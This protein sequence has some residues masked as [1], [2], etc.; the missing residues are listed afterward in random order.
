MA[1][2]G[3]GREVDTVVPATPKSTKAESTTDLYDSLP[4]WE[5]WRRTA[6]ICPKA[7]LKGQC[8]VMV[9][10]R[11]APCHTRTTGSRFYSCVIKVDC[12]DLSRVQ[13]EHHRSVSGCLGELDAVM[14]EKCSGPMNSTQTLSV[15]LTSSGLRVRASGHP[16]L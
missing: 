12:T 9:E 15:A 13:N 6:D 5:T 2:S 16:H 14:C 3:L 1:L 4:P 10:N 7:V 11:G 8:C